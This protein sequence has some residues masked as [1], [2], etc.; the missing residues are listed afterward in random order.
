[1]A[2][3]IDICNMALARI[4]HSDRIADL[5]EKSKAARTCK[6]FYEQCRDYVLRDFDWPFAMAHIA[7]A[8]LGSPPL[9]WAYRYQYPN[10]C[11]KARYINVPGIRRFAEEQLI[12]FEVAAGSNGRVILTDIA[13]AELVYTKAVTDP[14]IFDPMF[15]SALAWKL[16]AEVAM[17]LS[18]EPA[19]AQSAG[20]AYL[21]E[22]GQAAAHAFNESQADAPILPEFIRARG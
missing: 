6:L 18:V 16:A 10:D 14:T 4:G 5:E 21:Y 2:S 3:T 9:N 17:P 19:I 22:I 20:Q 12:P 13:A 15:V 11:L 8:D 1:M 7:L